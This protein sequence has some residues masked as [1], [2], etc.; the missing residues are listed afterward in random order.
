MKE[1]NS[2][3][4]LSYTCPETNMP[5]SGRNRQFPCDRRP[6]L[7]V[8]RGSPAHYFRQ[9]LGKQSI[10]GPDGAHVVGCEH[11]T[12]LHVAHHEQRAPEG[13]SA[14]LMIRRT[15][16]NVPQRFLRRS[17]SFDQGAE[18]L[19]LQRKCSVR[20]PVRARQREMLFD[21]RRAQSHRSHR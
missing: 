2:H 16:L 11:F 17:H 5:A 8:A 9:M 1:K 3:T 7:Y 13:Q 18:F 20:P 4:T 10:G 19:R 12:F 6:L 15:I 14:T 21:E